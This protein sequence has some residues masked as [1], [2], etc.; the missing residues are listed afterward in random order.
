MSRQMP[1]SELA[2]SMPFFP[3]TLLPWKAK[4]SR[5]RLGAAI[6]WLAGDVSAVG[7]WRPVLTREKVVSPPFG[8]LA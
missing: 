3:Q 6:D 2:K 5:Q 8:L 7:L 1:E 4:I